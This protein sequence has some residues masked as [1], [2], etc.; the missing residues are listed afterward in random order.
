MSEI[1]L[2]GKLMVAVACGLVMVLAVRL[3]RPQELSRRHFDLLA[4]VLTG[5]SRI[6]LFMTVFV[7]LGED[8]QS[9]V[10]KYFDEGIRV[11]AGQMVYRDFESSYSP[12]FPYLAAGVL[13]I[14]SSAKALVAASIIIELI[15]I[16]LWLAVAR[17]WFSER[18]TRT[19]TLLYILSPIPLLNVALNGQNQVWQALLLAIA[20]LLLAKRDFTSGFAF[21]LT[22]AAVKALGLLFAPVLWLFARGRMVW[23]VGFVLLPAW[24]YAILI[25]GGVDVLV[26]IRVQ[27]MHVTSGNL[28][29]LLSVTGLD[30]ELL[31][32]KSASTAALFVALM[33]VFLIA[34]G[35]GVRARPRNV[36]FLT[37]LVLLTMLLVSKKAYTSY[38]VL[39]F[40]PIC[41][42]IAARPPSLP[43]LM[44]F[45]LIGIVGA[46]EPSLWFRWMEKHSLE[47]LW[48]ADL[49]EDVSRGKAV[50]FLL[51][52]L[53]L[54][55]GYFWCFARTWPLMWSDPPGEDA[56]A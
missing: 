42:S 56:P 3:R 28:F 9:D 49:P 18:V 25:I 55:V 20:L 47:I 44:F 13:A 45:A 2:L 31:A 32:M 37:A 33:A 21:G 30:L 14:W 46:L 38:L 52:D 17:R 5:A 7:V 54:L 10:N 43:F 35:R 6:G 40:F 19:A 48:L 36:V 53:I 4:M 16:P 22:I 41:L 29:Y 34:W 24:V 1:V 12:L 50:A 27:G 15:S 39:A 8:T 51:C 11:L 26:P 23:L